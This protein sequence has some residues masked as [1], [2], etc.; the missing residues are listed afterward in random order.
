ML[1]GWCPDPPA[2]P[3]GADGARHLVRRAVLIEEIGDAVEDRLP[4]V[5]LDAAQR[6]DAVADK[7]IRAVVDHLVRELD[8]EVRGVVVVTVGLEREGILMA[9]DPHDQEVR[10]LFA[11]PNARDDGPEIV[12]VDLV[13]EVTGPR[14]DYE[15]GL[16]QAQPVGRLVGR[17]GRHRQRH[18]ANGGRR[19]NRG[20]VS[21]PASGPRRPRSRRSGAMD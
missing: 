9:V 18:L 2:P 4:L 3:G 19:S 20:S 7:G 17:N 8:Q 11:D 15:A 14:A 10:E 12:L 1:A 6:M 21:A 13:A 16:E 5:D